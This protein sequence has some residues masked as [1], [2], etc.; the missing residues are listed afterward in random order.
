[1]AS[2]WPDNWEKRVTGEECSVCAAVRTDAPYGD[3]VIFQSRW[4]VATLRRHDIQR[5]YAVVAWRDG[6]VVEPL[7][8]PDDAAAA[9]WADVLRVA[10][11]VRMHFRP[12]KLNFE[13]L[14][15]TE[16]HLH[17]HIVPRYDEDPNPGGN[18]P[19]WLVEDPPLLPVDAVAGDAEALRALLS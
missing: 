1:M 15:N 4:T 12:K 14:G 16:P 19:F 9:Y 17:T 2:R 10:R 18:F 13:T 8:L 7:D 3:P 6:H 11:A 5:G